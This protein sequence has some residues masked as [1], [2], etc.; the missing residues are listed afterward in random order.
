[1]LSESIHSSDLELENDDDDYLG[2]KEILKRDIMRQVMPQKFSL[3]QQSALNNL[4]DEFNEFNISKSV[5]GF[6][7]GNRADLSADMQNLRASEK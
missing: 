5:C 3:N 1:M 4:A 7:S 6:P 2:F